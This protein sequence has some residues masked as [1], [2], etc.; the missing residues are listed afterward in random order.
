[1]PKVCQISIVAFYCIKG[2]IECVSA[3]HVETTIVK[4]MQK[5]YEDI[6]FRF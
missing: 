2:R 4:M 6:V 3:K 1:M 5:L